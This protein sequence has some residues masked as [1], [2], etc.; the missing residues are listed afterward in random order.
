MG[1]LTDWQYRISLVVDN[2]NVDGDQAAFPLPIHISASCGISSADR[3]FI[4][5]RLQSNANRKKIAVT[6]S[7]GITEI[8]V[9]IEIWDHANEKALL[10]APP[11]ITAASTTQLYL[12][13]DITHADNANV[14]DITDAVTHDVWDANYLSVYHMAQDP[15]GDPANGMKDSTSNQDDGSPDG[16]MTTA[17]LVDGQVGKAIDFDSSDHIDIAN[18]ASPGTGVFTIMILF[19]TNNNYSGGEGFLYSNYG[20]GFAD[21]IQLSV[22]TSNF[23]FGRLRDASSNT[24]EPTGNEA[25]N[26]NAYHLATL[27]RTTQTTATLYLDD[28]SS[29]WSV[30]NG[31]SGDIDVSDGPTPQLAQLSSFDTNPFADII[32]EVRISDTNR[33]V[34]YIKATWHG[35][36]DNLITL[37]AEQ[38][39]H[40]ELIEAIALGDAISGSGIPILV[41]LT[42]A[43]DLNDSISIQGSIYLAAL[44]E[45]IALDDTIDRIAV[46]ERVLTEAVDLNDLFDSINW[47]QFLSDN[48]DGLIIRYY[49][50]LTG[51]PA[52]FG[53]STSGASPSEDMSAESDVAFDI[54]VD[55]DTVET[56]TFDWTGADTGALI[57][58]EMQTKIQALGGD[59]ASVTVEFT[60]DLYVITSSTTSLDSLVVVTPASSLNATDDLK[61]GVA[62]SGTEI[63]GSDLTTDIE[64]PIKSFQGRLRD[65]DPTYLSVVV[66]GLVFNGIDYSEEINAR[67][68]GDLKIEMAYLVDGVEQA[69]EVLVEVDLEIIRIDEGGIVQTITLSGHRT[70][71]F[72]YFEVIDIAIVDAG[73]NLGNSGFLVFS[74]GL[75]S[76]AA[77]TYRRFGDGSFRDAAISAGGF[78]A[79]TPDVTTNLQSGQPFNGEITSTMQSVSTAKTVILEGSVFY[80]LDDNGKINYRFVQPDLFLKP[81]DTVQ[82]RDDEFTVGLITYFVDVS[83]QLMNLTEE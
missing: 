53:T 47:T 76:G 35:L 79:G 34:N 5:D 10:W 24:M 19:R 41:T 16:G 30:S 78:Y 31:S 45:A 74:G 59:K 37:G 66:P 69:R 26:D 32:D 43:I 52:T 1:W 38:D 15:N 3:S 49:F 56:V 4:F 73:S 8:K 83:N 33:S 72:N 36:N 60:D 70:E 21:S 39:S 11:N 82:T 51:T 71:H 62:D 20:D 23:L 13:Y 28:G 48:A 77:G 61:L 14:G 75:G 58:A 27:V 42:E 6:T 63:S 57:A 80:A 40:V 7:D 65:G 67:F 18:G 81:G 22:N 2:T 17:D 54:S 64:I 44:T 9:E 29:S 55:G 12:Y 68:N 25:V 50:T 46:F